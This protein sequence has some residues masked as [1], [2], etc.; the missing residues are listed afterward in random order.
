VTPAPD[1]TPDV[2]TPLG[3]LRLAYDSVRELLARRD[4]LRTVEQA[5]AAF[6]SLLSAESAALAALVRRRAALRSQLL[7]PTIDT[8]SHEE[9]IPPPPMPVGGSRSGGRVLFNPPPPAAKPPAEAKQR[10]RRLVNRW[11]SVWGLDDGLLARINAIVDNAEHLTGEALALLPW[12]VF[13]RPT[14]PREGAATYLAR[15]RDWGDALGE[16]REG[17]ASEVQRL[18][19][20]YRGLLGI[21]E[22]WRLRESGPEGEARWQAFVGEKRRAVAAEAEAVRGTI[23]ELERQLSRGAHLP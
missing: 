7:R 23:A 22:L 12:T 15:L 5:Q 13:A 3:K 8:T 2:G 17:L 9:L 1:S 14:S 10:F 16:Y 6:E 21:W 4:E 18:E 20:R 19:V 11:S